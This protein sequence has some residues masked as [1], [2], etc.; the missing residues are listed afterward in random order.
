MATL[1]LLIIVI[2]IV[3]MSS[4]KQLIKLSI[5]IKLWKTSKAQM[6]KLSCS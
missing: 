2:V 3:M 5:A 1:A 6:K 4:M